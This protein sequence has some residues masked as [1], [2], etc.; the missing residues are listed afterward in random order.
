MIAYINRCFRGAKGAKNLLGCQK[1]TFTWAWY[2]I[3][4]LR[5]VSSATMRTVQQNDNAPYRWN[6]LYKWHACGV[7]GCHIACTFRLPI[8]N[9]NCGTWTNHS[10]LIDTFDNSFYRSHFPG[11]LTHWGGTYVVQLSRVCIQIARSGPSIR[12]KIA[13]WEC[14]WDSIHVVG[15]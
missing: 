1:S 14:N 6:N 11:A 5:N 3:S 8:L 4:D 15:L 2:L 13:L 12:N 9:R 10:I 7:P